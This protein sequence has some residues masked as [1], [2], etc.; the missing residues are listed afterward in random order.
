MEQKMIKKSKR[1]ELMLIR[2][3]SIINIHL[4]VGV[5]NFVKTDQFGSDGYDALCVII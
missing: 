3:L 5:Y 2:L 1:A 4:G